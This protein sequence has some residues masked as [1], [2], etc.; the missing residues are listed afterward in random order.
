[1]L[2]LWIKNGKVF[3]EGK[4]TEASVGVK[5]GSFGYYRKISDSG[6]Y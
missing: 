1:M 4:F 2:D 6:C 3:L 5:N